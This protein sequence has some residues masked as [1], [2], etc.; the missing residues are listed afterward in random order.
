MDGRWQ[1]E[2]LVADG[3]CG[4]ILAARSF[5]IQADKDWSLKEVLVDSR[6]LLFLELATF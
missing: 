1:V 4:K 5:K 3:D 2:D 6:D